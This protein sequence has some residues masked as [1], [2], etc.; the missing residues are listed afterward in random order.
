VSIEAEDGDDIARVYIECD[1]ISVSDE[2]LSLPE[3]SYQQQL[4]SVVGYTP[5][6]SHV[7]RV[8]V[9]DSKGGQ[10]VASSRWTD[11]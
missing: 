5:G 2:T 3:V 8:T 6:S 9:N 10:K 1:G 7:V 11:R 4:A